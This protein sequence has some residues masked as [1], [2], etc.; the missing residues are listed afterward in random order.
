[1][2]LNSFFP[3]ANGRYVLKGQVG[4]IAKVL[5][6]GDESG[7]ARLHDGM[8]RGRVPIPGRTKVET[9]RHESDAHLP[10]S[11]RKLYYMRTEC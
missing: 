10:D 5:L 1:M 11:Y 7:A 4:T 8:K 6:G 9:C 2:L 3:P